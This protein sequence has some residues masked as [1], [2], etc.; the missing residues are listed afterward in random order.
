MWYT[1]IMKADLNIVLTE[2]KQHVAWVRYVYG[3][4]DNGWVLSNS[5]KL[6]VSETDELTE[7]FIRTF[8]PEYYGEFFE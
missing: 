8:Y 2:V 4:T 6:P 7:R 1:L 5:V 3:L